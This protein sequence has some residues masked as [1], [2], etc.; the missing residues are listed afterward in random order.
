MILVTG[1]TGYTGPFVVEALLR[2][3]E[4]VRA[5]VRRTSDTAALQRAG[6][7]TV[8]GNL[9]ED[10][11]LLDAL[12]GVEA[13]VA[14]SHI[15]HAPALVRACAARGVTR[16][17]FFSSARLTSRVPS[18]TVREVIDGEAA[19][20]GSRLDFTLLRPT[21]I[22]GPGDDRNIS[23]LRRH[24]RTHRVIPVFGSGERPQQPVFVRDVAQAMP[25]T[26]CRASTARKAY[27][28]AGPKPISYIRLIDAIA[29]AEGR[30]IVKVYLPVRA[31]AWAVGIYERSSSAPRITAEQVRRFD[32]AKAFDI[33][34]AR[35]DFGYDPVPFEEGL[36]LSKL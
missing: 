13:L 2:A 19:V 12:D 1:A 18:P 21:M 11:S 16:A 24:I 29:A 34:D 5:L 27:V 7:E 10:P 33:S 30:W 36:R 17:V 28:L 23:R 4:K 3:E 8:V 15:R 35:R 25:Q 31:S 20:T 22:Y 32:E 26:L 14:V 6:I 9:E